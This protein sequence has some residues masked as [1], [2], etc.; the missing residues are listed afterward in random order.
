[1][2]RVGFGGV[3][4]FLTGFEPPDRANGR[5]PQRAGA[6]GPAGGGLGGPGGIGGLGGVA[7]GGGTGRPI[8]D[9]VSQTFE[10]LLDR[11]GVR[12]DAI[13]DPAQR[14]QDRVGRL[15]D[16]L[17]RDPGLLQRL[18]RE[19]PAVFRQL[20]QFRNALEGMLPSLSG[21]EAQAANDAIALID[22][23]SGGGSTSGKPIVPPTSQL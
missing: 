10:R 23:T 21:P 15:R 14:L 19:E 4:A 13:G 6:I 2:N 18:Q 22:A 12:F 20:Q 5:M 1:M 3:A 16:A 9:Q 7:A 17:D 11:A 8:L